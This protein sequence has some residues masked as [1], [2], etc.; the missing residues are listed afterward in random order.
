MPTI[1][2]IEKEVG[3]TEEEASMCGC[4]MRE[5]P[6]ENC[7]SLG[8]RLGADDVIDDKS[9]AANNLPDCTQ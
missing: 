8:W 5:E 1:T 2:E 9:E 6:C 7:W 3:W 4:Y